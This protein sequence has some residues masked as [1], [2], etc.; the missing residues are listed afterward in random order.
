MAVI[1]HTQEPYGLLA[2]IKKAIDDGK[3]NTWSYD[4]IAF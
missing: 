3:V 1:I 4:S 2:A